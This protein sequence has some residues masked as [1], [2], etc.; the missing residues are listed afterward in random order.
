M[1]DYIHG[2][3]GYRMGF[4]QWDC[5]HLGFWDLTLKHPCKV[6]KVVVVSN[7]AGISPF[8]CWLGPRETIPKI[9]IVVAGSLRNI[10]IST[11]NIPHPICCFIS[12]LHKKNYPPKFWAKT[13]KALE[14]SL[15]TSCSQRARVTWMWSCLKHQIWC[16][17]CYIWLVV[18]DLF[19][20]SIYWE[21]HHPNWLSYFSEE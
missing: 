14:C 20:F 1:G 21:F 13:T 5:P 2:F 9:S 17:G 7:L 3:P 18:W 6:W 19:S 11:K 15:A 10:L 12:W 8:L 4:L 16:Q